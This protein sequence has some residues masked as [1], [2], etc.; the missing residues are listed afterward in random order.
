M[1]KALALSLAL[2]V[3]ASTVPAHAAP[4]LACNPIKRAALKAFA[5]YYVAV[6]N[7]RDPS[8][9]GLIFSDD[10]VLDSTA[11]YFEG[12]DQYTAVMAGVFIGMPDIDYTIEEILVDGD[13][14]V[15]RYHYTGTHLG[16]L[17]GF[18]P[19][20]DV[21]TCS[22]LEINRVANG[23][24]YESLNFTDLNCLLMGLS[25]Q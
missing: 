4:G 24:I 17:F 14:F 23:R 22:G 3:T 13:Q 6:V 25:G 12:L 16:E 9:F 11:G 1:F 19:T 21:I 10:I 18:P 2:A 7:Q 15:L 20:G 5:H 8:L